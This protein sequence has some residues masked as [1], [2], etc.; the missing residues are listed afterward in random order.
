MAGLLPVPCIFHA[1]FLCLL[2]SGINLLE[3]ALLALQNDDNETAEEMMNRHVAHEGTYYQDAD[4]LIE[5]IKQHHES[6]EESFSAAMQAN[7]LTRI[8]D[9]IHN[10]C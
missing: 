7:S 5:C 8:C 10:S 6:I 2:A 1:T 9:H 4:Q 3:R